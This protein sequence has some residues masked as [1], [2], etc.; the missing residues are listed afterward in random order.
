LRTFFSQSLTQ[1]FGSGHGKGQPLCMQTY[2][3]FFSTYRTPGEEKDQLLLV[4]NHNNDTDH[5]IVASRNQVR[6]STICSL[7]QF[8]HIP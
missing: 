3:H 6:L 2:K 5:I 1:D 4:D 8:C 7:I